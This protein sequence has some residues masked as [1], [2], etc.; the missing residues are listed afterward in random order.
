[1]NTDQKIIYLIFSADTVFEGASS[2][3]KTLREEKVKGSF[4]LTG[5]CLRK[6]EFTKI[7]KKIIKDG[8]Y[9]GAHSDNHLLYAPWDDRPKSLV[10]GDSL[11]HDLLS[12]MKE[13]ARFGIRIEDVKYYLPP[14]EWYNKDNVFQIEAVGQ[15]VI[16]FTSG[17]RT[18]ADYTTPDMKNYRSSQE[19]I[20]FLY[21]FEEENTLNG[22][23]VLIHPG[24]H[25]DRTDKLYNRLSEIIKHL[26]KKGYRFARF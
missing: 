1:M 19:L 24:T 26:K 14:Y 20:D 18:N 15:E 6:K 13:L 8:H 12:N 22:C 21:K 11:Q 16:N 9:V 17:I 23:I 10:S 7:I 3:L 25:K 4:F 2:V 5:N